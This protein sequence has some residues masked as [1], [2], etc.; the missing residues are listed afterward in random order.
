MKKV[1]VGLSAV[2][3]IGAI[4]LSAPLSGCNSGGSCTY[5]S[6]CEAD[7]TPTQDETTTCNNKLQNP[8]C[9]GHWSDYLGCYQSHQVCFAN[10]T[11]DQD[12]S[13]AP[14]N[15]LLARYQNCCFGGE[16]GVNDAGFPLCQ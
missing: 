9:G 7:P 13:N 16:G 8:N 11:T 5:V 12:G 14:C 2:A 6:K 3:C 10:G 15:D 4:V 1:V